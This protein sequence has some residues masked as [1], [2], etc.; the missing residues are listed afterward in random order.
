M[1]VRRIALASLIA[2]TF[3]VGGCGMMGS[4]DQGGGVMNVPLAGKNEVPP[5][6]STGSGTGRVERDGN[7]LKWNIT[8]SG[9]TG[10]FPAG[11]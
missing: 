4:R 7:V 6:A 10:P 11:H 1:I 2:A 5:N 9:P 8:Y 3:A